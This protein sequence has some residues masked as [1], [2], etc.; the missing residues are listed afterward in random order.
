MSVGDGQLQVQLRSEQLNAGP[1]LFNTPFGAGQSFPSFQEDLTAAY[2]ER[3][4][5]EIQGLGPVSVLFTGSAFSHGEPIL[6][7]A[8]EPSRGVGT[9]D[10]S[11][12]AVKALYR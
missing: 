3:L 5:V 6:D 10:S 2:R 1:Q 12:G 8:V 11:W 9:E 7:V 4:V